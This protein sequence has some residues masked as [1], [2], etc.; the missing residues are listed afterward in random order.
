MSTSARIHLDAA[1]GLDPMACTWGLLIGVPLQTAGAWVGAMAW[2]LE[3]GPL[4]DAVLAGIPLIAAASLT[5]GALTSALGGA[6]PDRRSATTQG[7][8]AGT[9]VSLSAFPPLLALLLGHL[10]HLRSAQA[11]QGLAALMPQ[12]ID[13][14]L[15]LVFT[16]SSLAF[17][18]AI[19]WGM[20]W[21]ALGGG[22][23]FR[24]SRE[25]AR[26]RP[27]ALGSAGLQVLLIGCI[28]GGPGL[29][30]CLQI[31]STLDVNGGPSLALQLS[32]IAFAAVLF[33]PG[34]IGAWLAARGARGFDAW[35]LV[36]RPPDPSKRD[37]IPA[38]RIFTA[39]T[40]VAC[41]VLALPIALSG[42]PVSPLC[43]LIM[44]TPALAA[45]RGTQAPASPQDDPQPLLPGVAVIASLSTP[46]PLLTAAA[47]PLAL[48]LVPNL[49]ED[50]S[51]FSP[52]LVLFLAG[53]VIAGGAFTNALVGQLVWWFANRKAEAGPT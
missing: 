52:P 21:G 40:L 2:P 30:A 47:V 39:S 17:C 14:C 34:V 50:P 18:C 49:S 13:D 33:L 31:L 37:P 23:L 43:A 35:R 42:Q 1:P 7:G 36:N 5:A 44:M 22:A 41:A 38:C 8:L 15:V 27:P 51:F 4:P 32:F 20:C 48:V 3:P 24:T 53:P 45:W 25:P 6:S 26:V 10:L 28:A 11:G 46:L 12:M 29:L 9:I 16:T 19:L